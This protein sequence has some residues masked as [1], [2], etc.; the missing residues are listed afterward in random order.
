MVPAPTPAP[1][2]KCVVTKSVC[3]ASMNLPAGGFEPWHVYKYLKVNT[4]GTVINGFIRTPEKDIMGGQTLTIMNA[5]IPLLASQF[6][7][8]RQDNEWK[9]RVQSAFLPNNILTMQRDNGISNTPN[10]P[11]AAHIVSEC[12]LQDVSLYRTLGGLLGLRLDYGHCTIPAQTTKQAFIMVGLKK[13]PDT[14]AVAATP[15]VRG[16]FEAVCERPNPA[17]VGSIDEALDIKKTQT[18]GANACFWSS[19]DM[20]MM[21]PLNPQALN[22]KCFNEAVAYAVYDSNNKFP[23]LPIRETDYNYLLSK[24]PA[25]EAVSDPCAPTNQPKKLYGYVTMDRVCV[26]LQGIDCATSCGKWCN[27]TTPNTAG[28]SNGPWMP[29]PMCIDCEMH[30]SIYA[31]LGTLFVVTMTYYSYLSATLSAVATWFYVPLPGYPE[32]DFL[33]INDNNMPYSAEVNPPLSC[34]TRLALFL[35]TGLWSIFAFYFMNLLD[36]AVCQ[37]FRLEQ[38]IRVFPYQY[39]FSTDFYKHVNGTAYDEH[40]LSLS[41]DH[42]GRWIWGQPTKELNIDVCPYRLWPMIVITWFSAYFLFCWWRSEQRVTIMKTVVTQTII[43]EE[44]GLGGGMAS[45][46]GG[47]TG[48]VPGMLTKTLA[49]LGGGMVPP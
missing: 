34:S 8:V 26:K 49:F 29:P 42:R 5:N 46:G 38:C 6:Q 17:P 1:P 9:A 19:A 39:W 47:H 40:L 16:F 32:K 15:G 44:E 7:C 27:S 22:N 12:L 10:K 21:S 11:E 2:P 25:A 3:I 4:A 33:D 28:T 48:G 31:I 20:E 45:V 36:W 14:V 13:V 41:D 37:L 24:L 35:G 18:L 43:R 30:E 23:V